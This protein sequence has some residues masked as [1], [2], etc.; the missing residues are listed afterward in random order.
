MVIAGMRMKHLIVSS[1]GLLTVGGVVLMSAEYRVR[2]N[3]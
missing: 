1:V 3:A 2:R